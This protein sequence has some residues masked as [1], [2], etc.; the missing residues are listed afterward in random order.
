M[1]NT[2]RTTP[3]FKIIEGSG[4]PIA[5]VT[6][7]S[8]LASLVHNLITNS[9]KFV[10]E[11][12]NHE[13]HFSFHEDDITLSSRFDEQTGYTVIEVADRGTGIA[14]DKLRNVFEKGSVGGIDGQGPGTGYGLKG[15][16][17]VYDH[18][19]RGLVVLQHKKTGLYVEVKSVENQGT[20]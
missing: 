18:H 6:D 13:D 15:S 9:F 16:R 4:V 14:N 11:K 5:S 19:E 8:A 2:Y 7:R 17:V 12:S 1:N 3:G 10:L 20:T